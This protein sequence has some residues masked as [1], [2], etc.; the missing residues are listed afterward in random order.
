MTERTKLVLMLV[1]LGWAWLVSV[2][3][4]WALKVSINNGHY[5]FELGFAIILAGLV[6]AI[7]VVCRDA[8]TGWGSRPEPAVQEPDLSG[9]EPPAEDD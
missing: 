9:V 3:F 1:A 5:G 2:A 8:V 4:A 7:A 6:I